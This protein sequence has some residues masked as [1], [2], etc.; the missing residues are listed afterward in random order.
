MFFTLGFSYE[1]QAESGQR[2]SRETYVLFSL[3]S[4]PV[5]NTEFDEAFCTA[6]LVG[7][8][9]VLPKLG[10]EFFYPRSN[11]LEIIVV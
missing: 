5:S 2:M 7:C 1:L 10:T 3:P 9:F 4:P 6:D 11:S 8:V